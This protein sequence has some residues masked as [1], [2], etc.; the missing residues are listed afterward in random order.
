M[1][2]FSFTFELCRGVD[3]VRHDPGDGLLHV[4][5][6]L[7]HLGVAH[8]IDVLDEVVVLL[9]ERHRGSGVESD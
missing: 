1:E 9:P 8:L 6:P 7:G 5:H 2:V 4:L 3:P